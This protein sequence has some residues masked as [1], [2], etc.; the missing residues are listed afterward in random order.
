MILARMPTIVPSAVKP[1]SQSTM[2]SLAWKEFSRCSRRSSIHLTGARIW[3]A[4]QQVERLLG[5]DVTLEPEAA[6]DVGTDHPQLVLREAHD[7]R[8]T[9][10]D[11]VRRL[12]RGPQ[13]E[14][15]VG[16]GPG[17]RRAPLHRMR[18]VAIGVEALPQDEGRPGKGAVDVS[19]GG[20]QPHH[21]V[22]TELLVDEGRP[23]LHRGLG[24]DHRLER[25]VLD[26]DQLGAILGDVAA[27]GEHRR[28]RLADVAD[29]ADGH[30]RPLALLEHGR[31]ED[32]LAERQTHGLERGRDVLAGEDAAHAGQPERRAGV[33][34]GDPGVRV[35]TADEGDVQGSR[36]PDVIHV[37]RL[38]AQEAWVFHPLD[39]CTHE[40]HQCHPRPPVRADA[41]TAGRSDACPR[42]K[43]RRASCSASINRATSSW[44][45][46]R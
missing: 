35:R 29:L 12:R 36:Q 8:R 18:A 4:N 24:I 13:R 17:E 1:I 32:L 34:A 39:G 25:L 14:I 33:D 7:V 2:S 6:A 38:P 44:S 40:F 37:L 20:R 9:S 42:R 22:V 27:V 15:A 11:E 30:A 10:A 31:R 3:R 41:G 5:K 19:D 28:H 26:L 16:L 43:K 23:G 46:Y 21:R 45:L